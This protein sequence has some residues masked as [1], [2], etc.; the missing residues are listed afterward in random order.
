[1]LAASN[2]LTAPALVVV[3]G[4]GSVLGVRCWGELAA[5]LVVAM[6]VTRWQCT[7]RLLVLLLLPILPLSLLEL[8]LERSWS[9]SWQ[10]QE[11]DD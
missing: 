8:D 3:V 6:L 10:E 11:E 2:K 5:C 7:S 1:M 4:R 9:P